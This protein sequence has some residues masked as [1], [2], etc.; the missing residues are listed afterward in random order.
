MVTNCSPNRL[1]DA[2]RALGAAASTSMENLGGTS[3]AGPTQGDS[4]SSQGDPSSSQ[5]GSNAISNGNPNSNNT[6]GNGGNQR[7]SSANN[8]PQG[9][10][11]SGDYVD[12]LAFAYQTMGGPLETWG[13]QGTIQVADVVQFTPAATSQCPN[14]LALN[15]ARR[16]VRPDVVD[17]VTDHVYFNNLHNDKPR[18]QAIINGMDVFVLT[19]PNTRFTSND[20][21]MLED[22]VQ[23]SEELCNMLIGH[24]LHAE[25]LSPDQLPLEVPVVLYAQRMQTHPFAITGL[26][27]CVKKVNDTNAIEIP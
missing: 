9:P 3:T 23:S 25:T 20:L 1:P 11:P 5:P 7:G 12:K 22:D 6:S 2:L 19:A 17:R 21:T 27:A 16:L 10:D 4:T 26:F 14:Q 8:G 18:V 13:V 15:S 24:F